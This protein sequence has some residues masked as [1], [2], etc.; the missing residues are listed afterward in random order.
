MEHVAL[1]VSEMAASRKTWKRNDL[2]LS[3]RVTVLKTMEREKL[4]QTELAKR[5][6]CSQSTISKILKN[7]DAILQQVGEHSVGTCKRKRSGKD[8]DVDA[9][10]Y[11][12]FVDAR[13][14]DAPVTSAVLE[15]KATHFATVLHK[16]DFK[17][18]NG[19]LCRWKARHGIKFKKCHGEKMD[20]DVDAADQWRSTV[21]PELLQ[22]YAPRDIYNADETG[23]YFRAVPDGTLSFTT[24]RLSGRKKAK[25]HVT[26][27]VCANMDGSDKR[28]LLIIG[29]SRMPCCFKNVAQLPT[30]YMN[31]SNAWM[32]STLFNKWLLDFNRDMVKE[33]R[34]IALVVDNCSAHLKSIGAELSN[35]TSFFSPQMLLLLSSLAI[36]GSSAI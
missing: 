23:I 33:D 16:S 12:W 8:N 13:A 10:L 35:I 1:R 2:S 22:E 9:A 21:L 15:E 34:H 19:W 4:P 17:V 29:K 7:K 27:L 24:D 5:F 30:P 36:W 18:T 25:E 28:P 32:T 20:A 26:A 14:R 11:T 3:Q 31:S 6:K